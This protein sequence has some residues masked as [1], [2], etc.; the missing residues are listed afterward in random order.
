MPRCRDCIFFDKGE[1]NPLDDNGF[2]RRH[3]PTAGS[4]G[5]PFPVISPSMDWCG[6]FEATQAKAGRFLLPEFQAW[7]HMQDSEGIADFQIDEDGII[8]GVLHLGVDGL[9]RLAFIKDMLMSQGVDINSID[10]I[11]SV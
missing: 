8:S 1:F 5:H 10:I 2:C 7:L 6:E 4:P 3:A 11:E 9:Q